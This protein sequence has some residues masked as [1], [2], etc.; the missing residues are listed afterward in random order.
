MCQALFQDFTCQLKARQL[1]QLSDLLKITQ[2]LPA[3]LIR[4]A[5]SRP[6]DFLRSKSGVGVGGGE[7]SGVIYP[8]K[9]S[10]SV[11]PI[12]SWLP[13]QLPVGTPL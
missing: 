2:G 1:R 12:K 3:T 5:S 10:S 9:W 11:F 13:C 4:V 6:A 7:E 8:G